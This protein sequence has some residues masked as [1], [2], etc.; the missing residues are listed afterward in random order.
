MWLA[1]FNFFVLFIALYEV[2]V[3]ANRQLPPIDDI[4]LYFLTCNLVSGWLMIVT[5]GLLG[6]GLLGLTRGSDL[7]EDKLTSPNLN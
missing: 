1:T 2:V 4:L 7:A 3:D 6:I 5:G